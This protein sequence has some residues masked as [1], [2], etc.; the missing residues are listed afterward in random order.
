M[1]KDHFPVTSSLSAVEEVRNLPD[2][3]FHTLGDNFFPQKA[4]GSG[5][6]KK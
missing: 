3:F 1:S 4:W 6:E 2:T 5:R